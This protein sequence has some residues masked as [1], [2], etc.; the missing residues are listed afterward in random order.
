MYTQPGGIFLTWEHSPSA[1]MQ[2]LVMRTWSVWPASSDEAACRERGPE[3]PFR[4]PCE[5]GFKSARFCDFEG[6]VTEIGKLSWLRGE[7]PA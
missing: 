7:K 3:S 4:I 6:C 5:C 1:L 2:R